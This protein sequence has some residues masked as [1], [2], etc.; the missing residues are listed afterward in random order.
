MTSKFNKLNNDIYSL[1][2]EFTSLNPPVPLS[3]PT[4]T[5]TPSPTPPSSPTPTSTPS[6]PRPYE[7]GAGTNTFVYTIENIKKAKDLG[8]ETSKDLYLALKSLG[9]HVFLAK[10]R[11]L[12]DLNALA[13]ALANVVPGM[14]S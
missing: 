12:K 6:K 4:P 2:G 11:D 7:T 3:S 13:T 8:D 10:E 14:K 1:I 9:D 5:P